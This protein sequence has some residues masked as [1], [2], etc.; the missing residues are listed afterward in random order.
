M[1]SKTT[2]HLIRAEDG[3]NV[4]KTLRGKLSAINCLEVTIE[5]RLISASVV[6]KVLFISLSMSFQQDI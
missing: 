1:T 2:R 4:S 6:M 3:V 5:D